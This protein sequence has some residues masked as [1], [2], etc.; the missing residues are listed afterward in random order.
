MEREKKDKNLT[1]DVKFVEM[2]QIF[3]RRP[4]PRWFTIRS[5]INSYETE[6]TLNLEGFTVVDIK[7]S[8]TRD[9]K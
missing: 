6:E 1:Q 8:L 5:T 3:S 9:T 4:K 7:I 2:M